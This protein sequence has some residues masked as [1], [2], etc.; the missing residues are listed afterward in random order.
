MSELPRPILQMIAKCCTTAVHLALG[1]TCKLIADIARSPLSWPDHIEVFADLCGKNKDRLS[2]LSHL[3]PTSLNIECRPHEPRVALPL[4]WL[5]DMR[6]LRS[7]RFGHCSI[8]AQEVH[9]LKALT[10]LATLD[11]RL[12]GT[13]AQHVARARLRSLTSLPNQATLTR[14]EF[15]V[16]ADADIPLTE[17]DLRG[18]FLVDQVLFLSSAILRVHLGLFSLLLCVMGVPDLCAWQLND[19]E[20]IFT[21]VRS[22]PLR[23]LHFPGWHVLNSYNGAVPLFNKFAST[24]TLQTLSLSAQFPDGVMNALLKCL[25]LQVCGRARLRMSADAMATSSPLAD[26]VFAAGSSEFDAV[27]R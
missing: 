20:F 12:E 16:L 26:S 2:S 23:A 22:F 19:Y 13:A 6:E 25:S 15:E 21:T 3:R 11:C 5:R 10:L 27:R 1:R 9:H 18:K 8:Q 14:K 4:A 24:G 17:M 7:L